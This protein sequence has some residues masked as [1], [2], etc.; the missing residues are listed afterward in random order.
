M[1][2]SVDSQSVSA[3]SPG[4]Y[5]RYTST[6]IADQRCFVIWMPVYFRSACMHPAHVAAPSVVGRLRFEDGA[7]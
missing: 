3:S 1:W 4:L 2:T 5:N 7:L 6:T